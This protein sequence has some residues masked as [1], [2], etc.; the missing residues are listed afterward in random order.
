MNTPALCV[1]FN[2]NAGRG[3]ARRRLEKLREALGDRAVFR[4]TEAPGHGEQL[5]F[6]AAT[7]GFAAVAAAGGDGTV[8]EVANGVLRAGLPEVTMEVYPVGSA[9]D[10]ACA[11]GLD[12]DWK[13]R[14]DPAVT[15]RPVDVGLVTTPDGRRRYFINGLGLGFNGHVARESRRVGFLQ[16]RL[17][18]NLALFRALWYHFDAPPM[19]IRLDDQTREGP[20]LVLCLSVGR[21]EGNF[22]LAPDALLDDGL[23][24]VLHVGQVRRWT[25]IRNLLHIN[26][27]RRPSHPLLWYGQS[28]GV[29]VES[30]TPLAVHLDGEL[31][32]EPGRE[33]LALDV[34]LLPG[35]LRVTAH[36]SKAA[37]RG[38]VEAWL[39]TATPRRPSRPAPR[40]SS[41]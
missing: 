12:P 30:A 36:T 38:S 31:I 10:Y 25:L 24:D 34:H 21:R 37:L 13:L 26:V 11:L 3:R 23:F 9:N 32:D 22:T 19:T 6:E 28:A 29:S 4:P 40:T 20:T 5:A 33:L 8:H 15:A 1:I 7:S 41:G 17:L 35:A 27:G 14:G 39:N 16:G 2:P 18:Y